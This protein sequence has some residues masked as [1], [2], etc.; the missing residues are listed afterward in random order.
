[1]ITV[2]DPAVSAVYDYR[3]AFETMSRVSAASGSAITP[4][5]RYLMHFTALQA[6]PLTQLDIWTG[7]G[8]IVGVTAARLG[9]Y[10]VAANGDVTLVAR[11]ALDATI[12]A[13]ASTE[14]PRALDATGGFPA[15]Y[16]LI[17]AQRYAASFYIAAGTPPTILG[18]SANSSLIAAAPRIMGFD[19]S[20]SGTDLNTS[21]T[22]AQIGNIGSMFYMAGLP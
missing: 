22:A 8:A 20:G 1:M 13:A 5:R 10:T 2:A 12:G 15:T 9:L 3:G 14:Y 4:G 17:R 6:L 7:A 16:T 18:V 19:N 11:T 21:L